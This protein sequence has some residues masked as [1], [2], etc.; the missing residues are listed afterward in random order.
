M[1]HVYSVTLGIL[2]K[3]LDE[4]FDLKFEVNQ[5]VLE[6][7]KG[8]VL[9][10]FA[11]LGYKD[12]AFSLSFFLLYLTCWYVGQVNTPYWTAGMIIV[13][14]VTAISVS[15]IDNIL[16]KLPLI[17]VPMLVIY[18]EEW[19][20]PEEQSA[21]KI[22]TRIALSAFFISMFIPQIHSFWEHRMGTDVKA[23]E[24]QML[25]WS[26]YLL[27]SVA[28]QVYNLYIKPTVI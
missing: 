27:T 21:G 11:L 22:A 13:G 20:H 15:P 1:D 24:K 14:L 19:M 8:V 5:T 10:L 25:I 23:G 18:L 17:L 4:I 7:I 12:F 26:G 2:V 16:W 9:V 3:V 28:H 6:L